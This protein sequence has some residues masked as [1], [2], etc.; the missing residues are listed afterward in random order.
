MAEPTFSINQNIFKA[1]HPP[2]SVTPCSSSHLTSKVLRDFLETVDGDGVIGVA[3]AYGAKCVLSVVAFASSTHV[4]L[5]RMSRSPKAKKGKVQGTDLLRD[6]IL[7]S[8]SHSKVAF[9]M[10]VLATSLYHDFKLRIRSGV[11]LLSVRF[12]DS[13]GSG[14]AIM[15]AVGGEVIFQKKNLLALFKTEEKFDKS[16]LEDVALQAWVAWRGATLPDIATL[17]KEAP[18]IDTSTFPK[19][20]GVPIIGLPSSSNNYSRA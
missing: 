20:V 1:P 14:A 9:R 13:R 8:P 4:L 18:R 19:E 15:S 3:P 10:D 12:G 16:Q 11:D 17:L 5:V 6:L 7:C 2:I